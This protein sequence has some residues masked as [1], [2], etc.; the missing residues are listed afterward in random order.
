MSD[1][2]SPL[3][4]GAELPAPAGALPEGFEVAEYAGRGGRALFAVYAQGRR[5]ASGM[6][7]EVSASRW[8][9]LLAA[10]RLWSAA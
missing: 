10:S 5:L 9:R 3:S 7:S 2:A 4:Y 8:A 6:T 1:Q